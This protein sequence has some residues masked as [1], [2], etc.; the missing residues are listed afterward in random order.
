MYFYV[1]M[2]RLNRLNIKTMQSL[3]ECLHETKNSDTSISPILD[4]YWTKVW[5]TQT[6]ASIKAVC[7][8]PEITVLTF[9]NVITVSGGVITLPVVQEKTFRADLL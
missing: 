7:C 3:L 2:H 5:H 4:T 6:H 1:A 8:P 9:D